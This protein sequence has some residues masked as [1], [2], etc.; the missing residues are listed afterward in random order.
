MFFAIHAM[1]CPPNRFTGLLNDEV[2]S[3]D[4]DETDTTPFARRNIP[5][6]TNLTK[7][8]PIFRSTLFDYLSTPDCR[9][10]APLFT[11]L[12]V[13]VAPVK[14]PKVK[15]QKKS[16]TSGCWTRSDIHQLAAFMKIRHEVVHRGRHVT[17]EE[18]ELFRDLLVKLEAAL[19]LP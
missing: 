5:L 3:A 1:A 7:M 17:Q 4:E 18:Y 14:N 16:Y 2:S 19:P 15:G 12:S 11:A 13:Q 6:D 10:I 8:K 9:R